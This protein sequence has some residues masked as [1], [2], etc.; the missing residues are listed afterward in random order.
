MVGWLLRSSI[1][2][3]LALV[4]SCS[5]LFLSYCPRPFLLHFILLFYYYS[6][7]CFFLLYTYCSHARG[8]LCGMHTPCIW[9]PFPTVYAKWSLVF[10]SF[11]TSSQRL[12]T[13]LRLV[14]NNNNLSSQRLKTALRLVYNNNNLSIVHESARIMVR[15][16]MTRVVH[17]YRTCVAGVAAVVW[18]WCGRWVYSSSPS[19]VVSPPST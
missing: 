9:S 6:C 7:V 16:G 13:A 14:Y 15:V 5:G 10:R 18:L 8:I 19:L 11:A 2:K 4:R 1:V 3:S 12:K 17:A